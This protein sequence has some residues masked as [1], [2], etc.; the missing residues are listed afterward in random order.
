MH[1]T[2]EY[3]EVEIASFLENF[4]CAY[5]MNDSLER[6]FTPHD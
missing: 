6:L 2:T 5:K 3:H 1:S 4:A